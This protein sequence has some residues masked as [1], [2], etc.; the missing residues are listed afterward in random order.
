MV[1]WHALGSVLTFD[2]ELI[3]HVGL[4]KEDWGHVPSNHFIPS[5]RLARGVSAQCGEKVLSIQIVP[6]NLFTPIASAHQMIDCSL[7]LDSQ[8]ARHRQLFDPIINLC[9]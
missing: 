8:L 3:I 5:T 4:P 1:H 2:T 6:K 9:Q 7:V